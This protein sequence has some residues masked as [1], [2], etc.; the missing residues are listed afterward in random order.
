[1]GAINIF[2]H[3]I[4]DL[5]ISFTT[6]LF[7]HASLDTERNNKADLIVFISWSL[8]SPLERF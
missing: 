4:T 2:V 6:A 7:N 1:M 3:Q 8:F 5:Q